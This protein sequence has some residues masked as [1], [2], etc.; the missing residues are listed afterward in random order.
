MTQKTAIELTIE[1]QQTTLYFAG[2]Q[3][4][5]PIGNQTIIGNP[6]KQLPASPRETE[7]AIMQIEDQIMPLYAKLPPAG[8]LHTHNPQIQL[9]AQLLGLETKPS[10]EITLKQVED[11]FNRLADIIHGRPASLDKLPIT[12]EFTLT[13]L[14]LREMLNHW[15]MTSVIVE[16][17]A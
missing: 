14:I 13:L 5:V 15:R 4:N 6:L 7:T 3:L 10:C 9:M 8:Q 17:P 2:Q 16:M 11:L 1:P 12:S